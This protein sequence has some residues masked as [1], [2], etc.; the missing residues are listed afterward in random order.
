MSDIP[1]QKIEELRAQLVKDRDAHAANAN[2]AGG[3][4]QACDLL[5]AVPEP[6]PTKTEEPA[7]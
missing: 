4:I 1:R 6:E 5:L 7:P 3:A 2:A